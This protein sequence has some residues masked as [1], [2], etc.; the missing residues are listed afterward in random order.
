M[1]F[2]QCVDKSWW[3]SG[4]GLQRS[5]LLFVEFHG[6]KVGLYMYA[7][8]MKCHHICYL[9]PGT[10]RFVS[11]HLLTSTTIFL[12]LWCSSGRPLAILL[13]Y[14]PLY[15]LILSSHLFFCLLHLCPGAISCKILLQ[16]PFDLSACPYNCIFFSL[17][18]DRTSG[19]GPVSVWILLFTL[20]D[21]CL[22]GSYYLPYTAAIKLDY[23]YYKLNNETLHRLKK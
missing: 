11:A 15:S 10:T 5:K 12:H 3:E 9:C 22:S 18:V 23:A 14:R 1:A 21:R 13:K 20:M 16:M 6:I 17:T 8:K 7:M 19:N 4:W 2:F